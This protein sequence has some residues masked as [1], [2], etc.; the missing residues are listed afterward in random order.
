[1]HRLVITAKDPRGNVGTLKKDF[2]LASA[3]TKDR[4]TVNITSEFVPKHLVV[5]PGSVISWRNAA[6]TPRSVIAYL[7]DFSSD[8][9]FTSDE[10]YA[11]GIPSGEQWVWIVPKDL[12]MGTM[13]YYHCRIKGQPGD[14][15]HFGSGL[16]GVIEIGNPTSPGQPAANAGPAAAAPPPGRR[17]GAPEE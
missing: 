13:I 5:L 14:G 8:T 2:I 15:D 1:M 17:P 6:A 4:I 7:K 10:I 11:D 16:T 12:D 9:H 3:D